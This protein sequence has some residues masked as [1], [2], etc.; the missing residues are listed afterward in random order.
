MKIVFV[1]RR[2][3]GQFRHLA[4]DLARR[5]SSVTVICEEIEERLPGV[6]FVTHREPDAAR[7]PDHATI[8]L[9][10]IDR[11]TRVA[12]ALLAMAKHRGQPDVVVGHIGWGSLLFAKDVLPQTPML[13]YCEYFYHAEGTDLDFDASRPPS[14]SDRKRL[15]LRNMTQLAT[16]ESVEAG[17]SPTGW[18]RD[19][20]P[21]ACRSRIAVCHDGIDTRLCAPDPRARFELPD[22]RAV[23]AG[24]PVVTYAARYFEPYRGFPQFMRAAKLVAE[25]HADAIFLVAGEDGNAYSPPRSDGSTWREAMMRETGIDPRRIVFLGRLS[26]A[27]LIKLFQVSA[28]HIYL[29]YPF[30]LSWSLL[31]AMSCG[32]FIVASDVPPVRE[33]VRSGHNGVLVDFWNPNALAE[34]VLGALRSDGR[35]QLRTAA[36]LS[37]QKSLDLEDCL[38]HQRSILARIL[39][40]PAGRH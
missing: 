4:T 15:K 12:D 39:Q 21:E 13:G 14:H 3:P 30:V 17:V 2:G 38:A 25:R 10:H 22:G 36:R 31:E 33:F 6:E 26:H 19:L 20:Y 8:S 1:H 7:R 11:A 35:L 32:T 5:G 16:L 40:G 24:A 23:S 27:K 28:A 18:Q 9:E 37:I 29:T 34:E